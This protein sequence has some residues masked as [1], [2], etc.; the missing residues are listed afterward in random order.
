[1]NDTKGWEVDTLRGH[2][3]NV[4]CVLFHPSQDLILS[5]SE[6]KTIRVWDMAKRTCLHTFRRDHDRFWIMAAHPEQ[7]VFAAGHDSGVIIFKLERERP[8]YSVYRGKRQTLLFY[9]KD[10]YLRSHDLENGKDSPLLSVRK[11]SSSWRCVGLSYN[12]AEN[13]VLLQSRTEESS[14]YELFHLQSSASDGGGSSSSSSSSKNMALGLDAL[15]CARN[16][17]AALE[18]GGMVVVRNLENEVVKRVSLPPLA[19]AASG[20][21]AATTGRVIVRSVEGALLLDVSRAAGDE[22][23]GRLAVPLLKAAVWSA[24]KEPGHGPQT[25]ALL[26][27]HCV[28]LCTRGTN[29]HSLVIFFFC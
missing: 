13:C 27:K 11:Q 18:R 25:L 2:F 16:K 20:L 3:N 15:F 14:S 4:S 8:P 6:D 24:R 10:R 12:A 19:A 22:V 1:M 17:F 21:L 5:N 29:A 26:G 7:N 28:V 9:V 23:V